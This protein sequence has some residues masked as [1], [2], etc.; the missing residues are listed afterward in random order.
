MTRDQ[1]LAKIKKCLAL[2]KSPNPNEAATAM[3]QAQ[4]LMAEHL[5][6]PDDVALADVTMK[7]CSTRMASTP[8]WEVML[9]RLICNAFGCEMIW[10]RDGGRLLTNRIAYTR[11]VVFYGIAN[12]PEIAGYAWDVLSRQCAKGRL[13]H[14]RKQPGRCKPITLSARGDQYAIGWVCGVREKLQAFAAPAPTLLLEQYMNATWPNNTAGKGSD[15]TKGRNVSTNDFYKGARDG[16]AASL[17]HGVG[18]MVQQGLL[19]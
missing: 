19:S 12:A 7:S 5:V 4:K 18:G 11:R 1:A 3:R 10:T 9:A 14:I 8:T 6:T 16:E 13:A 17:N 2:G 15:R